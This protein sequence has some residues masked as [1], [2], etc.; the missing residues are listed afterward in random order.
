M[1]YLGCP[2]QEI[3]R[4]RLYVN[5][6]TESAPYAVLHP[7]AA[8]QYKTWPADRFVAVAEHVRQA[9]RLEPI[10]I[11]SSTDDM[12]PFQSFKTV[13]GAPLADIIS[14]IA[15]ASLFIGN[16]SGPAH[17]AAAFDKPLV[18]LFGRAEHQITWAPWRATSAATLVDPDGIAAI[19]T[20]GVVAAVK[21]V[22]SFR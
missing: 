10:F 21:Q 11:G 6:K 2:S 1:F 17:I 7:V 12:T 19:R 8:A 14:F 13:V 20:E 16:D 3:A 18:V 4:A 5:A 9:C 15:G 22:H